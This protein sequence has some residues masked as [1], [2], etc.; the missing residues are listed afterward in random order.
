MSNLYCDMV[1]NGITLYS[2]MACLNNVPI[3]NY[4]YLGFV[5]TLFFWDTQG[6]NNPS[7]PGLNSR[8]QL[9]YAAPGAAP[10]QISILDVPAQQFD[11]ILGTQNCTISLYTK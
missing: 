8:Y 2:G 7:S 11:T 3:G 5:G 4:G 1:L 9:I 10:L 6:G